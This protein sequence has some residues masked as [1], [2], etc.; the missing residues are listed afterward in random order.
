MPTKSNSEQK[1]TLIP[2]ANMQSKKIASGK[3]TP[4]E[5]ISLVSVVTRKGKN[6]SGNGHLSPTMPPPPAVKPAEAVKGGEAAVSGVTAWNDGATINGLWCI[7]QDKNAWFSD[8]AL[9]WKQLSNLSDS[10][11]AALTMLCSHAK[12]KGSTVNYRTEDDNLVHEIY[13]W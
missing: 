7:N 4:M 11:N 2:P 9:G 10:G 3:T 5:N 12:Q 13:V 1:P 8:A 6:G